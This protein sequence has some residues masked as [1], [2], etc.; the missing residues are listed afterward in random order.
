MIMM[1]THF[2]KNIPFREVYIHGLVR[3]AERKKMS[4][5]KGNVV[6]PLEKMKEYGTD[7]FRFF[8]M[9]ILPEGKDIV[10]DE[11]RLRGYQSFCN[12]IWNTARYLWMNQPSDYRVSDVSHSDIVFSE[13]DYWIIQHFNQTLLKIEDAIIHYRF[14]EYAQEIYNF[15]WK[16][17]CDYYIEL[18]KISLNNAALKKSTLYTLNLI[19]KNILKL[20]HPIMPFITEE[21]YS[22]WRENEQSSDEHPYIIVSSWPVEIQLD[23]HSNHFTTVENIVD[24]IY[25]IRNIRGELSIPANKKLNAAFS[26][27]SQEMASA[28]KKY[29]DHIAALTKLSQMSF[30]D[31]NN[32]ERGVKIVLLSGTLFV[33]IFDQIDIEQENIRLKKEREK[34]KKELTSLESR[35]KNSDFI[36][37]APQNIV[38]KE[39]ERVEFLDKKLNGVQELLEKL[40]S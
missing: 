35:M 4:K 1:S 24:I 17:F 39:K 19:F 16:F 40:R 28:T 5:S 7:A 8:M 34:I 18:A 23:E 14:A 32:Q 3:D 15:T 26:F 20:L 9:G 30:V 36:K 37:K 29:R 10:Y 22:Y 6:D 12:K 27:N 38:A 21:L 13:V 11:S 31:E 25:H 2:M 33:D